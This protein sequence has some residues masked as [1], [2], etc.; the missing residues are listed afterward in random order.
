MGVEKLRVVF[1]FDN[2]RAFNSFVDSGWEFGGQSSFAAKAEHTSNAESEV[3]SFTFQN[4]RGV[5]LT[6]VKLDKPFAGAPPDS[7]QQVQL[8]EFLE[9][10]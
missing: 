3:I 10:P 2:E 5:R 9:Q 7:A 8:E 4:G 1:V 6:I